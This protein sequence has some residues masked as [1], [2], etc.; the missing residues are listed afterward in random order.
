MVGISSRGRAVASLSLCRVP[1]QLWWRRRQNAS[2]CV[3]CWRTWM[4]PSQ[5]SRRVRRETRTRTRFDRQ[6]KRSASGSRLSSRPSDRSR[7]GSERPTWTTKA[8]KALVEEALG[9]AE[10]DPA[11]ERGQR[12]EGKG[13][14]RGGGGGENRKGRQC[15]ECAE[16]LDQ[17]PITNESSAVGGRTT[18]C[19]G[20]SSEGELQPMAR[21]IRCP[22]ASVPAS[23]TARPNAGGVAVAPF[24]Y[25]FAKK[26]YNCACRGG[27]AQCRDTIDRERRRRRRWATFSARVEI[28][29]I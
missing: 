5:L 17:V 29:T 20:R 8:N 28:P 24:A 7:R 9:Q 27:G 21:A 4:H 14:G 15:A 22:G 16:L 6:S 3:P 2:I 23:T 12:R 25:S 26:R 11:G 18:E 10:V 13:A 19:T 1:L